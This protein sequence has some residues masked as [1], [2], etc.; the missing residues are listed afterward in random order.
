MIQLQF[1]N[2][3]S[4]VVDAGF[5]VKEPGLSHSV[6]HLSTVEHIQSPLQHH[7]LATLGYDFRLICGKKSSGEFAVNLC[8]LCCC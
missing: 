6:H 1:L 2:N 5:L 3:L 7:I 4:S 8:A